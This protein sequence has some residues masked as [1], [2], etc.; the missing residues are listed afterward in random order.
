MKLRKYLKKLYRPRSLL[1]PTKN[2]IDLPRRLVEKYHNKII[3]DVG[4]GRQ[5]WNY[6]VLTLDKFETA[7]V[8]G[9]AGFLPVR[10]ESTDL[11]LSIAVLEH[12][13]NPLTALGEM[14]RVLR[15][16][17]EIYIE[18]PFLQPFHGSP[19]DYYRVTLNGLRQWCQDF[20][21]I[22]SG[23]CVGPGS[24]VA[25]LEIEYIRLWFG[26]IPLIGLVVEL[27][28]RIWTLPLKFLDRYLISRKNV[29]Y[30]ASA[31][32]FYGRKQ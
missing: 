15:P 20:K 4:A 11:I 30:L 10:S 18:V 6:R 22:K 21:E 12:V 23:V 31:V 8:R 29:D 7:D 24:A 5:R 26:N 32:Y 14:Q 13:P 9:D 16:G 17:G 1:D 19:N 27:L 25:W 2:Y 28:F 3:L